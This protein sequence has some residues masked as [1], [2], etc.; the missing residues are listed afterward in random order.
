MTPTP[1]LEITNLGFANGNRVFAKCENRN[2]VSHSHYDRVYSY[3]FDKCLQRKD[4]KRGKTHLIETSSGN[5]GTAF[6]KYCER[7]G[8]S[9]TV[10]FPKEV[11]P[12]RVAAT[13]AKNVSVEVAPYDG[14]MK[15][16]LK[17]MLEIV[18]A[19]KREGRDI[20]IMNHSQTFD[21][22]VAMEKC[23]DE[24]TKQLLRLNLEPGVFIS[25]LGNGT[26]TTGIALSL[27][28]D[29]QNLEVVGFE[30]KQSPVFTNKVARANDA[31]YRT[32]EI[33]GTGVWGIP[34]PNMHLD[35]LSRIEL[36]D[37]DAESKRRWADIREQVRGQFNESIGLTSCVAID[38]ARRTCETVSNQNLLVIFYDIGEYY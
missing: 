2:K 16:A 9:G 29:F 10:V 36:V 34:F 27:R 15:G 26:S 7:Y 21:S 1:L 32:S 19:A 20:Y 23:G 8:F 24:I 17:R 22:V 35:L 28:E 30:P 31:S 11:R 14:Y 13:V 6:A 37:E 25:A 3:L 4:I 12:A 38:V 18:K 33:T 5:A